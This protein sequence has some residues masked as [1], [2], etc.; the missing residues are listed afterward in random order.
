VTL[1]NLK[2]SSLSKTKPSE[3]A[4]QMA[5]LKMI[6]QGEHFYNELTRIYNEKKI[7]KLIH[8]RKNMMKMHKTLV[9]NKKERKLSSSSE[10]DG[11]H[12]EHGDQVV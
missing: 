3:D 9:N 10:E 7:K 1:R 6:P 11:D 12:K 5:R 2:S 8:A 4:A